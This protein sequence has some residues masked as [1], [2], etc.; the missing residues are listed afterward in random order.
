LVTPTLKLSVAVWKPSSLTVTSTANGVARSSAKTWLMLKLNW[1]APRVMT[2]TGVP[3]PQLMLALRPAGSWSAGSVKLTVRLKRRP[4]PML[5]SLPASTVMTSAGPATV[6]ALLPAT[7]LPSSS[8]TVVTMVTAA[9]LAKLWVSCRLAGRSA[10][11][12]SCG[13]VPSPQSML[14]WVTVSAPGSTTL[15]RLRV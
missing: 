10:A 14:Y 13:G 7:K 5:V 3:S 15:P 1:P 6:M 12:M 4:S 2:S 11:A 9:A 8:V